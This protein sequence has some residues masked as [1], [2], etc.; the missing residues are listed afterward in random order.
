[1]AIATFWVTYQFLAEVSMLL[2]LEIS[3]T[4][5]V[6]MLQTNFITTRNYAITHYYTLEEVPWHLGPKKIKK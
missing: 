2:W 6:K 4:L 1:M 5:D 3:K